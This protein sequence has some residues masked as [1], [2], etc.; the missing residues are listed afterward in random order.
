MERRLVAWYCLGCGEEY[1]N[2]LL[3]K[4]LKLLDDDGIYLC[5]EC[6][7]RWQAYKDI[8]EK[9]FAGVACD[10]WS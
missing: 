9:G 8:M 3:A 1:P 5:P 7:P 4:L 6:F 2:R 10:E